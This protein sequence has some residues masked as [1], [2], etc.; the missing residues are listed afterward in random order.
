MPRFRLVACFLLLLATGCAPAPPSDAELIGLFN[1]ER[2]T[3]EQAR[4]SAL[5][6]AGDRYI[7]IAEDEAVHGSLPPFTPDLRRLF[8]EHGVSLVQVGGKRPPL[9]SFAM[10][11][12]GLVTGGTSKSIEWRAEL[13]ANVPVL[14]SLDDPSDRR[15]FVTD[16]WFSAYRPIGG[17]WYL[18]LSKD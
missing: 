11:R 7:R 18:Y 6:K 1:R 2:T 17:G 12:S 8:E 5:S 13:P 14:A 15:G 9:V 16:T 4:D 10:H 3:F